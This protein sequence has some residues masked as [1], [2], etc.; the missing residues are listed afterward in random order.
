M[1][2]PITALWAGLLGLLMLALAI[3]V[4]RT[5]VSQKVGFGDGGNPLMQQRIRVHG[6]F[7]EYVPM[8]L[9]LMLVLEIDGTS[10]GVLHALGGGLFAA[11]LLHAFGLGSSVGTTPGRFG[12]TVLTWLV[13]LFASGLALYSFLSRT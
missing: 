9:L 5:R 10:P 12:G 6:N 7:I 3:Q 8:V 4:V 11:R 13:L 1:Q 2:A